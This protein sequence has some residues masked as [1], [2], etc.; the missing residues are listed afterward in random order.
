[1]QLLIGIPVKPFGVAKARL[2][3]QLTPAQR[4][5][6]GKNIAHHTALEATKTGAH[7]AVVTASDAVASWARH[8]SVDVVT[9]SGE[10]G[11]N[12]AA[13]DVVGAAG[14]L[15]WM[16]LHAD[17]PLLTS[18]DLL[19]A[20][21]RWEEGRT[22]ISPSHDGG[23]SLIMATGPFPFAFG[24]GSFHRHVKAAGAGAAVI[25]RTGLALDLDTPRDLEA[26]NALG[27]SATWHGVPA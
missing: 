26:A 12:G 2:S 4:S 15:P 23:T 27:M 6:L 10:N 17:L 9:E 13:A 16:I 20:I 5:L 24:P 14:D 1:V 3:E 21:D 19:A 22:V 8:M 25:I 11:L 7:V 18:N